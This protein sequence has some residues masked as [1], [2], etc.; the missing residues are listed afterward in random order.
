MLELKTMVLFFLHPVSAFYVVKRERSRYRA[1]FSCLLYL[2]AFAAQYVYIL[3]VH[4]PLSDMRPHESNIA[5]ELVKLLLPVLTWVVASY[6]VTASMSGET[7]LKDIFN[8]SAL[9]MLPVI[10]FKPLAAAL[11]Q[12]L[13]QGEQGLFDVINAGILIWMILGLFVALL[14]MNDYRLR[15]ALG[16]TIASLIGMLILWAVAILIYALS[17]QLVVFINSILVELRTN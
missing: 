6:G 12:I 3:T 1:R 7:K 9:C 5:L 15:K 10:V 14:T 4:Y 11:S 17:S 13:S 8:T 16:V 2:L